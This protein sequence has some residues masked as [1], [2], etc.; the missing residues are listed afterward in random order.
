[1]ALLTPYDVQTR[2]LLS[3]VALRSI[4]YGGICR[5]LLVFFFF[6]RFEVLVTPPEA[7]TCCWFCCARADTQ[8]KYEKRALAFEKE[9]KNAV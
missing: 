9:S 4:F 1:M 3:F 8:S 5:I 6:D 7:A 2:L